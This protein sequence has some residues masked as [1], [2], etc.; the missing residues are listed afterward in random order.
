MATPPE[1]RQIIDERVDALDRQAA[2]M[3]KSVAKFEWHLRRHETPPDALFDAWVEGCMREDLDP[4]G[5]WE[6]LERPLRQRLDALFGIRPKGW[7]WKTNQPATDPVW[8]SADYDWPSDPVDKVLSPALQRAGAFDHARRQKLA[9]LVTLLEDVRE[10]AACQRLAHSAGDVDKATDLTLRVF[11]AA[12]AEMRR[13]VR[14]TPGDPPEV[15]PRLSNVLSPLHG[16]WSKHSWEVYR[17]RRRKMNKRAPARTR[18]G[19]A[20]NRP[21]LGPKKGWAAE[22]ERKVIAQLGPLLPDST[23]KATRDLARKA[24]TAI[25]VRARRG[26]QGELDAAIELSRIRVHEKVRERLLRAIGTKQVRVGRK[27]G[28]YGQK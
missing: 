16:L 14:D 15:D 24:L 5:R 13:L 26:I 20:A 10:E 23:V 18:E 22:V 27:R 2:Q 7:P 1:R 17:D 3:A 21:V 11:W 25:G 8:G 6:W 19:R 9:A 28:R 12:V 4:E